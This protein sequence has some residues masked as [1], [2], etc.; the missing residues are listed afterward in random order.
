MNYS[1]RSTILAAEFAAIIAVFSQLTIPFGII[2]LTGQTLAVGLAVTVLGRKTGTFAILIYLLL[3]L[4]GLPV[5]SGMSGGIGVLF[6]PTGGYLIGF[7]V[8]GL[9]TGYILERTSFTYSWAIIGNIVGAMLTLVFGTIWL[10]IYGGS[11]WIGA[12]QG[13][14]LPFIIPGLIKAILAGYLGILVRNR[15]QFLVPKS[16]NSIHR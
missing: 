13:A 12:F 9:V 10:K 5:F 14:F 1:L 15:L 8:N 4:I 3:G 7:I 16:E 6:G 2:P 11:G